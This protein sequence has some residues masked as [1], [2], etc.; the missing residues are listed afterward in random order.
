M[1][2][3]RYCSPACRQQACRERRERRAVEKYEGLL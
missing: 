2:R 1:G 3:K